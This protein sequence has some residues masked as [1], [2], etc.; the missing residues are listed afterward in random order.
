MSVRSY[1]NAEET[2]GSALLCYAMLGLEKS[3]NLLF[4]FDGRRRSALSFASSI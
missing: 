2:Y 3:A 1:A 4:P